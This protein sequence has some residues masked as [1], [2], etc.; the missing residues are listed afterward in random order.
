MQGMYLK[1]L[2][3]KDFRNQRRF[4]IAAGVF[5]LLPHVIAGAALIV[6]HVGKLLA[7]GDEWILFFYAATMADLGIAALLTAFIAGNAIAGERGDRSA[8]F[9]AYLPIPRK[10]AITSKAIVALGISVVL[11]VACAGLTLFTESLCP[12]HLRRQEPLPEVAAFIVS[13]ALGFGGA[14]LASSFSRSAA[15]AAA[16]GI[17]FPV[18]IGIALGI[19][20]ELEVMA[21]VHMGSVYFVLCLLIGPISF[22]AGIVYYLRRV[23]P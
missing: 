16:V 13:A 2:L 10:D 23:E 3:W 9:I 21:H 14:W 17:A 20:S 4:L 18:C 22:V 12:P 19:L 1:T 6:T 15:Y 5:L 8:E 11:L 7:R